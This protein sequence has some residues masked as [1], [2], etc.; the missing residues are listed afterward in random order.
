LF[1]FKIEK[2]TAGSSSEATSLLMTVQRGGSAGATGA[3]SKYGSSSVIA[4]AQGEDKDSE[5]EAHTGT[6]FTG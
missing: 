6:Y 5:Q 4:N 1:S 2:M 3:S